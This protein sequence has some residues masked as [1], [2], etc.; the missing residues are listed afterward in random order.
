VVSGI[1]KRPQRAAERRAQKPSFD[2]RTRIHY[3][4]RANSSPGQFAIILT[5]S[6]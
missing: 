5:A 1:G 2:R 3:V 4:P 6:W